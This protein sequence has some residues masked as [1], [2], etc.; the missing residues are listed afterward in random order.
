[1]IESKT[2]PSR[3]LIFWLISIV[4]V[5][6]IVEV[7][8][9]L[10]GYLLLGHVTWDYWVTGLVVAILAAGFL[11]FFGL[12]FFALKEELLTS[13]QALRAS[14]EQN[15][16]NDEAIFKDRNFVHL[17]TETIE[18]IF[19]IADPQL[20]R[21]FYIS[22][23]F[24]KIWGRS[25][26]SL[27]ESPMSFMDAVHP[28]DREKMLEQMQRQSRD[29]PFE[30][31]YR[32]IRPDGSV[33][34]IIDRGFP[35]RD[36][37]GRIKHLVGLAQ[38]ITRRKEA[39]SRATEAAQ[40]YR[41]LVDTC[42]DGIWVIEASTGRILDV[43]P[44]GCR[45]TGYSRETLLTMKVSDIDASDTSPEQVSERI[46]LQSSGGWG[47]F[48]TRHRTRSG[49]MDVEVDLF[50]DIQP[51]RFISFTRDITARKQA[52]SD[53]AR[54]AD[55]YA[56]M[57]KTTK[58]AFWLVDSVSARLMDVN[59]RAV[60]MFGYSREEMLARSI[61]DFDVAHTPEEFVTHIEQIQRDGGAIFETR[62]R[63][64]D[65][66][67]MD[68][69]V[70][71]TFDSVNQ[72]YLAFIRDVTERNLAQRALKE[73]NSR[74]EEH[75]AARTQELMQRTEAL[76]QSEERLRLA[77]EGAG[78]GTWHCFIP[79][80]QVEFS[81]R[82]RELWGLSADAPTSCDALVERI[83]PD[84][85]PRVESVL[86][87]A[88]TEL[89][90]FAVEFRI[91]RPPGASGHWVAV[92]GHAY[93]E[94]DRQVARL[95]G[96]ILDIDDRKQAELAMKDLNIALEMRVAE[97]TA[98]LEA[99]NAA[100]SQFLA[101]MSHEIRTPMNAV[102]GLAQLLGQ[103]PLETDQARMVSH[104]AEAGEALLRVINDI[105]DLSKIEAGQLG[106][107]Q[108]PF[109]LPPVLGRVRNL[110]GLSAEQKGLELAI[111]I[112]TAPAD[113]WLGDA[114]RLEQILINLLGNAIKFTPQGSVR[115]AIA[116]VAD[117]PAGARLRFEVRDT[118]IGMSPEVRQQ[119]FQPFN[120]G[121]SSITRRFGG[122]GLGLSICKRLVD[123]M[124]GEIG[125]ISEEGHGSTFWFELP[126]RRAERQPEPVGADQPAPRADSPNFR[127]LRVLAVDDN[128]INLMVL[129]KALKNEGAEVT[130]AGDG[131]H[132]L[133]L[134]RTRPDHF[135]VVL[136][137]VQMPVMDGLTATRE[138][139]RDPALRAVPV[140]ALTAGV[141]PE[142]RQATLDAG[143]NGFL[144]KPLDLRDMRA[145]LA[146]CLGKV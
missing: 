13:R 4:L 111:D 56:R 41:N 131:Q 67:I 83:H 52:A 69:E 132:A 120:Q 70:S 75:V 115:L 80:Y 88:L 29:E 137:D 55:T 39:E 54:S 113:A 34:W 130:L 78:L 12:R 125:V 98:Q 38:D 87:R 143:A 96:I 94:S 110:L 133:D 28:D 126:L 22:P 129:E 16:L 61:M 109:T 64:A 72:R 134:L 77:I 107:E 76:K 5:I 19:W 63:R 48:E 23:A 91:T 3:H 142:E 35:F 73:L 57:L 44:S 17:I 51:D 124:G 86:N 93:P 58:D 102:L 79:T 141:L 146:R 7:I 135:Q 66:R 145:V 37:T 53:L 100:K 65:G 11:Y 45:M 2:L 60:A 105:L 68:V 15:R 40:R 144:A 119:L 24:E 81:P 31:E 43:N 85:R 97:R 90:D 84:D 122:T 108:H 9:G 25:R 114:A 103:E 127:G 33:R 10:T 136:M 140:V 138:I 71:T 117:L 112:A 123:L 74:L 50:P 46:A 62:H 8:V 36:D 20:Q 32:I 18:E 106:I 128:R 92:M 82:S 6:A 26:E 21:I 47:R 30:N 1:M 101:H 118:G 121:D 49:L 99:A 95:E 139:R 89:G 59:D 14:Q 116:R 104:I 42:P 27:Y